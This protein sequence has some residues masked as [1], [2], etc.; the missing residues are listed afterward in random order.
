MPPEKPLIHYHH[1]ELSLDHPSS[2]EG[3][4]GRTVFP[5]DVS[6]GISGLRRPH[7]NLSSSTTTMAGAASPLGG[8]NSPNSMG[9]TAS[10]DSTS[11]SP[12]M[13]GSVHQQQQSQPSLQLP[14]SQLP[15]HQTQAAQYQHS[16]SPPPGAASRP[17]TGGHARSTNTSGEGPGGARAGAMTTSSASLDRS[18]RSGQVGSNGSMVS[19]ST[20][21]SQKLAK[22]FANPRDAPEEVRM[23]RCHS[24]TSNTLDEGRSWIVFIPRI[25]FA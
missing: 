5:D 10:L 23:R 9:F 3:G 16:S 15:Q 1:H 19:M 21:T 17:S 4:E 11:S 20:T 12:G 22:K 18:H 24:D 14:P 13:P 8:L 2:S 6:D 25:F 7:F